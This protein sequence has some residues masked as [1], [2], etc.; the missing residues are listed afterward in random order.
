MAKEAILEAEPHQFLIRVM[1]GR[2]FRRAGDDGGRRTTDCYPT[3]PQSIDAAQLLL[4]KIAPDLRAQ[5]ITGAG[6]GPVSTIAVNV[7]EDAQILSRAF[8]AGNSSVD[9]NSESP[10]NLKSDKLEGDAIEAAKAV[11]FAAEL[12]KRTGRPALVPAGESPAPVKANGALESDAP[13]QPSEGDTEPVDEMPAEPPP[14]EVGSVLRFLGHDVHISVGPGDRPGLPA[15]DSLC[16]AAG[17][18]RRG[19]FPQMLELARQQM[20][21]R[22]PWTMPWTLETPAPVAFEPSR[23]NQQPNVG[24]PP[25]VLHRRP[26]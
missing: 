12:A 15:V 18:C 5:E 19:P 16:N 3:L 21:D 2:K 1:D 20:G 11:A 8:S 26:G 14:P 17:L 13:V 6:G 22:G 10:K 7:I 25:V 23:P 9:E 24:P 4:R